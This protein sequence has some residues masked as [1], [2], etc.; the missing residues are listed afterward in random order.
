MMSDVVETVFLNIGCRAE[1]FGIDNDGD[2]LK[3]SNQLVHAT[4]LV[5]V[6]TGGANNYKDLLTKSVSRN[7]NVSYMEQMGRPVAVSQRKG[8]LSGVTSFFTGK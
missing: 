1:E 4:A 3:V 2:I 8:F 6:G 7:E 5:L